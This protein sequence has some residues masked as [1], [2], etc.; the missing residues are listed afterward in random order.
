MLQNSKILFQSK[1]Q[2]IDNRMQEIE[3]G[4]AQ[5]YEEELQNVRSEQTKEIEKNSQYEAD[6]IADCNADHDSQLAKCQSNTIMSQNLKE[7]KIKNIER[8]RE[9]DTTAIK[10][11]VTT[12]RSGINVKYNKKINSINDSIALV[13]QQFGRKKNV[14]SQLKNFVG[15]KDD[16]KA[17]QLPSAQGRRLT[18]QVV[19]QP[20]DRHLVPLLRG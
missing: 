12:L 19:N 18:C 11:E 4:A 2:Q 6:L 9:D 10:I 14:M 17:R 3:S 7:T 5:Y 1:L 20:E 8:S 16:N 15:K 13:K